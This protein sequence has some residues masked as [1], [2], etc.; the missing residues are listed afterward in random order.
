MGRIEEKQAQKRKEIALRAIPLIDQYGFQ[1]ITIAELCRRLDLSVGSFY[2]YFHD[3]NDIIMELFTLID[4]YYKGY[5]ERQILEHPNKLFSI[6]AFCL[7][8]G[9]YSVACGLE[10]CRQI[11]L[12]PL[13]SFEEKFM[14]KSRYMNLLL[15]SVIAQGQALGQISPAYTQEQLTDV[16]L[17]MIRGYC[18]DWCK[19]NA[20]YDIVGAI[21]THCH[22]L[23]NQI[24]SDDALCKQ[25]LQCA[26]MPDED[27]RFHETI[28]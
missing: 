19:Q 8:Y 16:F 25:A 1:H 10:V 28:S 24:S 4:G 20:S 21:E 7:K 13:V 3:K 22:M 15:S 9:Y 17:T 6:K 14:S 27:F 12:V 11:S 5:V 2:H 23:L 18:F 26:V